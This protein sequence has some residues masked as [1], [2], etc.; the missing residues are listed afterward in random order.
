MNLRVGNIFR[1]LIVFLLAFAAHWSFASEAPRAASGVLDLREWDWEAD[2]TAHLDGDWAFYWLQLLSPDAMPAAD[3]ATTYFPVPKHW[4]GETAGGQQLNAQGFATYRLR[5]LLPPSEAVIALKIPPL[6]SS[7]SLWVNGTALA[8]SGQVADRREAYTPAYSPG[9]FAIPGSEKMLD[10]VLQIAN[11]HHRNGGPGF[12]LKIGTHQQILRQ[13]R[14]HS[15]YEIFLLA[16]LFVMAVYHFGFFVLRKKEA[17][18]LY[19]GLFCAVAFLRVPLE[20]QYIF[21]QLFPE[22]DLVLTLKIDYLTFM[23]IGLSFCLFLYELFPD[24]WQRGV[25]K[26]MV[27]G[28][29]IFTLLVIALPLPTTAWSVPTGQLFVLLGGGYCVYVVV[30]AI[31]NKRDG[32]V[33]MLIA[34]LIFILF[35]INDILYYSEQLGVGVL[36]TSATFFFIFIQSFLLSS[37]YSNA[38]SLTELYARTFQKFV[39]IQFLDRI[40]KNGISSIALGNAETEDAVILFSDIRGFTRLSEQMSADEVFAFLN[41]YL[42]RMEPP[43]RDNEGFVDKYLGDAIMAL[44]PLHDP[45][46]SSRNALRAAIGMQSA[47]AAYN[48]EREKA[49]QAP[50]DVGIGLH[51]GEVIIGTVGGGERMDS[52]A[53]GDSVNLAS[54]V[55]GI[56][57]LYRVSV[58]ASEDVIKALDTRTEFRMRFIDRVRVV[59]KLV[60]IGIWEIVGLATDPTHAAEMAHIALFEKATDHYFQRD[61][62]QAKAEFEA[63]LQLVPEDFVARMY[64]DRCAALQQTGVPADWDGV[65]DLESK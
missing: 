62:V 5:V 12:G 9:V 15:L 51:F 57:K 17:S 27:I 48:A 4:N 43:V 52:T 6:R 29:G 24:E 56:T 13:N 55:E 3:A 19:F 11:F 16:S 42:S 54:R 37:R 21:Y 38:F 14:N 39:P 2:G 10:L 26:A 30:R 23:F 22:A 31:R 44:F 49:G 41:N 65:T 53:I 40:A 33:M 45:A 20:G 36:T 50:L 60:P 18:A 28:N 25:L 1:L 46:K 63:F 32:A 58:L 64:V 47:L 7:F 59:G 61:F 35:Y 8:R 34:L